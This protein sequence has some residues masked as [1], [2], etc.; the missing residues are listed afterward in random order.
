MWATVTGWVI[1]IFFLLV[2]LGALSSAAIISGVLLLIVAAVLFPPLNALAKRSWNVGLSFW[3]KLT[4][5][6]VGFIAAML[7]STTILPH[8][9]GRASEDEILTDGPVALAPNMSQTTASQEPAVPPG[10]D[11]NA[12]NISAIALRLEQLPSQYQA[13]NSWGE[14][15][16]RTKPSFGSLCNALLSTPGGVGLPGFESMEAFSN[17]EC[18]EAALAHY[19][20]LTYDNELLP[21]FHYEVVEFNSS[22]AAQTYFGQLQKSARTNMNIQEDTGTYGDED[23]E[24]HIDKTYTNFGEVIAKQ[25]FVIYLRKGPFI[26]AVDTWYIDSDKN[27]AVAIATA[28]ELHNN[29]C[30]T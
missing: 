13:K 17:V 23:L 15:A 30:G 9:S 6:I 11:V 18:S 4:I 26:A 25:P 12:L 29:L 20:T 7:F 19:V 27:R 2:A 24:Y 8:Q 28:Q 10:C 14:F 21:K 3:F 22:E 5:V 16:Y 1:A